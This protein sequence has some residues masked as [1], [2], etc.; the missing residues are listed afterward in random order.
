MIKPPKESKEVLENK[1]DLIIGI[2][3]VAA[4]IAGIAGA[5][6]AFL[7]DEPAQKET[8]VIEPADDYMLD[9]EEEIAEGLSDK[10]L[11][12][13]IAGFESYNK[14][15]KALLDACGAVESEADF[16]SLM[17][18]VDE[19]GDN[20]LENTAN[21][22]EVRNKLIDQGYGEHPE[23]GPLMGRSEMLVESMST[24]MELLAL[25]FGG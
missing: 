22:G 9:T 5:V 23:L 8:E 10:E 24:C 6:V 7:P 11:Q 2:V 14:S 12:T 4:V 19:H 13:V 15:V 25:E 20:F 16:R 1:R 3:V 21:Y 17:R 18:T